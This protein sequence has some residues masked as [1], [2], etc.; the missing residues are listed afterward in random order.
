[1]TYDSDSTHLIEYSGVRSTEI[2]G[3]VCVWTREGRVGTLN[4][5][6][7]SYAKGKGERIGCMFIDLRIDNSW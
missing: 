3:A 5:R 1:M 7:C 4:K 6:G 2:G